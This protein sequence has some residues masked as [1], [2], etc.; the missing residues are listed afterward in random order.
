MGNED[1]K[2][3]FEMSLFLCGYDIREA[4]INKLLGS[5]QKKEPKNISFMGKMLKQYIHP[6]LKWKLNLFPEGITNEILDLLLYLIQDNYKRGQENNTVLCFCESSK[7]VEII[8]AFCNIIPVYHPMIV[9]ITTDINFTKDVLFQQITNQNFNMTIDKRNIFV[10]QYNENNV[11][12]V[13]ICLLKICSYYN[14][15]GDSFQFPKVDKQDEFMSKMVDQSGQIHLSGNRDSNPYKINILICGRSG[16]GKST[17]INLFLSEK[18]CKE[19][20][21]ISVTRKI[22]K[23]NHPYFPIS[24]YDT[25]GFTETEEMGK[26]WKKIEH[27]NDDLMKGSDKIHMIWFLINSQSAR[28]LVGNDGDFI[29]RTIK[30]KIPIYF[31]I[32]RSLTPGRGKEFKDVLIVSLQQLLYTTPG[33]NIEN[34]TKKIYPVNLLDEVDPNLNINIK[35]FG[36]GNFLKDI[37][38]D[39]VVNKVDIEAL[40]NIEGENAAK[41]NEQIRKIV[42]HSIFFEHLR[43]LEDFIKMRGSL[44]KKIIASYSLLAGAIGA[45]PI[46]VADWFILTPLQVTMIM[47][48]AAVYKRYTSEQD[49]KAI[50]ASLG[51]NFT[52]SAVG[53]GVA[54]GLKAIPFLG[55][56]VGGILDTSISSATTAYIGF[57]AMGI[58]EKE[59]REKGEQVLFEEAAS[60]YNIAIDSF[61]IIRNNFNN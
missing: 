5:P 28:T 9:F 53:R 35:S 38:I 43:N 12:E 58:F 40:Q 4:Y 41:R 10:E 44:A 19:G 47:S 13:Y 39:L 16:V 60:K 49:A 57:T 26:V 27:L 3:S 36:V 8:K 22:V 15:L 1:G 42:K 52:L 34:V 54:S 25:P 32:T 2:P 29:K 50:I 7:A 51:V 31:I 20:K 18:R 33:V 56:I 48:I 55:T 45:S 24:I 21:G 59:M 14:E 37:Y 46:P 6:S 30:L 11:M 61:N 23:Y 17:F